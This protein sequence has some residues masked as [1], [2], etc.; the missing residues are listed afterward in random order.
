MEELKL[1][2]EWQFSYDVLPDTIK[3]QNVYPV[4]IENVTSASEMQNEKNTSERK[5]TKTTTENGILVYSAFT[6]KTLIN[7]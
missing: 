5:P 3:D 2:K 6:D 1:N 4:H 7:T